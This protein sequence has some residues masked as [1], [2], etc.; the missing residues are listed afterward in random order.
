MH[1]YVAA[2]PSLGLEEEMPDLTLRCGVFSVAIEDT[3]AGIV[4]ARVDDMMTGVLDIGGRVQDHAQDVVNAAQKIVLDPHA[5][6]SVP[7]PVQTRESVAVVTAPALM[8]ATSD[9]PNRVL[10][11]VQ[12]VAQPTLLH[13]PSSRSY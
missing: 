13:H 1:E 12:H 5:A 7:D 6:T 2:G 11:L 10:D 9:A 8:I 3:L 4:M